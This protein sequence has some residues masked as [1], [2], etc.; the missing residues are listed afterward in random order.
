MNN[1][2]TE[3]DVSNDIAIISMVCRFPGIES[4]EQYWELLAEGVDALQLKP[5]ASNDPGI[6]S[7]NRLSDSSPIRVNTALEHTARFDAPFFKLTAKEAEIM[8]PQHRLFLESAWEAVEKAGYNALEYEGL[9]GLFAGVSSSTYLI[10][11]LLGAREK[12][13]SVS[14]LQL[15]IGNDKDHMT[16]QV[17]YRL[18]IRGP[19]VAVQTSCSTSLVATHLACE[20]LLSGQCDM[21]LAGGVTIKYPQVPGYVHQQ[22]G[23]TSTDG[24]IK[25]FDAEATG[26]VYSNGLGIIV[27]KRLEDAIRDRDTIHAVIKGSAINSDGANRIGYAAP[28]VDGQAS[29]IAEAL[30]IAQIPP[31]AISYIETH[32]SG[33]PLGDDIELEALSRAF[34][35]VRKTRFCAIGSAKTNVGH[36]EMASGMA[37]LIKTVLALKHRQIPASLHFETPNPRLEEPDCPFYVNNMLTDWSAGDYGRFAGVSSFGLGGIN[38]H[39]ILTEAPKPQRLTEE[40]N[41][42]DCELLAISAKTRQALARMCTN[43]DQYLTDHPD[44]N[45]QDLAYTLKTGRAVFDHRAAVVFRDRDDLQRQFR[46]MDLDHAA[47]LN[48][49]SKVYYHFSS[50]PVLSIKAVA[51]LYG[52]SP[53]FRQI[54]SEI[55]LAIREAYPFDLKAAIQSDHAVDTPLTE[56]LASWGIQTSLARLF[57]KWGIEPSGM[58]GEGVGDWVAQSLSGRCSISHALEQVVRAGEQDQAPTLQYSLSSLETGFVLELGSP[59]STDSGKLFHATDDGPGWLQTRLASLWVAGVKPDWQ[60]YYAHVQRAKLELPT[61]PFERETYWVGP[62]SSSLVSAGS[63]KSPQ[64]DVKDYR[65][66]IKSVWENSLGVEITRSQ[67]TFF[68]LGGHSLLATQILFMLNKTL[69][70]EITMQQFFDHPTVEELAALVKDQVNNGLGLYTDLPEVE[71][72]LAERFAPFPLTDVQKA[73]WIGRSEDLDLGNVSTHMYFE[74]D[75]P[76]LEISRFEQVIDKMVER[77]E[78]LRAVMLPNGQQQILPKVPKYRIRNHDMRFAS[79]EVRQH[80]MESLREEMSHQMLDCYNW[81]LFDIRA[82][83]LP[84]DVVRLHISVDLLIADAWSLELLIRDISAAYLEPETELQP[85]ELSFRDYILA[86]EQIEHTDLFRRSEAYWLERLDTLPMG[87]QLELVKDPA[88]IEKPEFRRRRHT[89]SR[90]NWQQL[91]KKAEGHGITPTVIL[92][93]AFAEI[94]TVWSRK[95]HF[96]LNLTLFNRLPL[97]P[98]VTEVIG[99]FTSLTLLE[100]DN[101]Q[102]APFLQR[103]IRHQQRL[104]QD[105]DHRYFS[106]VRVTRELL[107]RSKEPSKAIVPIIFTSILNQGDNLQEDEADAYAAA[108]EERYSVSQTP[109]VWL[110][111]QVMERGGDL[112]LNWDAVEELF[113]QGMLDEMFAAYC[114]LLELLA[115]SDEIWDMPLPLSAQEASILPHREQLRGVEAYHSMGSTSEAAKRPSSLLDGYH[116]HVRTR[117]HAAAVITSERELTY[118]ELNDY[119]DYVA[120][121]LLGLGIEPGEPV[122]VVMTKGWEQ[123]AAVLGILKA[124]AAYL[125]VD[126]SLPPSKI[127]ELL[128]LGEVRAAVIQP[129]ISQAEWPRLEAVPLTSECAPEGAYGEMDSGAEERLAYIIYTSGSTG[130]P[131]GVMI[132]HRGAVNTIEAVIDKFAIGRD[133]VMLGLSSL[134]FDLSVFDIFGMLSAGGSV[135]LPDKNRLRDPAH[136]LDLMTRTGVTLWNTVPAL[137]NMLTEYC[138]DMASETLSTLRLV[139]LSGDWIPLG[140][141]DALRRFHEQTEI[142]SLGGATEASIWSIYF[143]VERVHPEWTSIPYGK[144]LRNQR[145]YVLNERM[146]ECPVGVCGE[147][148]VG[149]MGVAM[150]YWKDEARTR[151]RFIRHP[152]TGERLYRTGDK[153]R[154]AKDGN[155]EFLGR[156]DLQI[157]V[158]GHRIELGE[159]EAALKA[160]PFVQDAV[161]VARGEG[162]SKRL[163]AYVKVDRE[164]AYGVT[165][166]EGEELITD[167]VERMVFKLS[168]PALRKDLSGAQYRLYSSDDPEQSVAPYLQ[169]RSYRRFKSEP[170]PQESFGEFAACLSQRTFDG[171]P[172]PKYQYGSAGGLYPVQVY[173]Y[174]KPNAVES[175]PCGLYYYDRKEHQLIL[176]EEDPQLDPFIHSPANRPVFEASAFSVFLIGCMD[177]IAPMY[178]RK[179]GLGYAMMEAGIISQLL[180]EKGP[181]HGMGLIQMGTLGFDM[182]RPLFRLRNSDVYLHCLLGGGIEPSQMTLEGQVEEMNL[183]SS[184]KG[185]HEEAKPDIGKAVTAYLKERLPA[186]MIP[187]DVHELETFPLTPNGKV[188]RQAISSVLSKPDEP[189]VNPAFSEKSQ[190]PEM[191]RIQSEIINA[192]R[193]VL[194]RDQISIHD[195]F[196]DLGGDS[197]SMVAVYRQLQSEFGSRLTMVELFRYTTIKDLTD[198]LYQ[199]A[200]AERKNHQQEAEEERANSRRSALQQFAGKMGSSTR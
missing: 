101:R 95:S 80:H 154:Y 64:Q 66:Y 15:M 123:V 117:P 89:L 34:T 84:G 144:S 86:C 153:G 45:L 134:S 116:R 124:K 111:H 195:N 112:H 79:E 139:L 107:A 150:G 1:L 148:W 187:S 183:Y 138:K 49:A 33:T 126:A 12:Q 60:S 173:F 143:P 43:L 93:S 69:S 18:N 152:L 132:D 182:I 104:L 125:P 179:E 156:D 23:L 197:V 147:L 88:L 151:E 17:A 149:G 196:F 192:W 180:E 159:I 27:L 106:G 8:D 6:E 136:W 175:L 155:I 76:E 22:G 135:V 50:M 82:T 35:S 189:R 3:Q 140:L 119:A 186:Y 61:Y 108:Q 103:A 71:N 44:A 171:L 110:D 72:K 178:G 40:N 52:Q 53:M 47:K 160:H 120:G 129:G 14:D 130:V 13:E 97:H 128:R 25:A 172:F 54:V 165:G 7:L 38:A 185:G 177:A 92:L 157:K 194:D 29:V 21:A 161:V 19:V 168:E 164:Q 167:S 105:M 11:H 181:E 198:F 42:A 190:H 36:V 65:E 102:L 115:T 162:D 131:K 96:S 163:S 145:V 67:E 41:K 39:L 5:A 10:N 91:K 24:R 122:A 26:T 31:Q 2:Q 133:D 28:G 99:D 32:G 20:S 51:D 62:L 166:L 109:Q 98:E 78:M 127:A 142:I 9:M 199:D 30:N 174:L 200:E 57:M 48:P 113:P 83:A 59:K 4:I 37:G 137:M 73:Y 121:K 75:V 87:P 114:R 68:E 90:T 176:M 16:S 141:P 94:I 56:R 63:M 188:D 58:S 169:R 85:L 70:T 184:K 46:N 100:I 193:Q 146:E 55:S 81:P 170:I 77:H 191:L 158:R 118:A 74:N